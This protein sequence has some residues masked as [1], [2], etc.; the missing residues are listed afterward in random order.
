MTPKYDSVADPYIDPDTGVLRNLLGATTAEKLEQAEAALTANRTRMLRVEPLAGNFD[1]KH[2]Q[3]IHGY[4]FQDVYDWAG[5]LR[6]SDI[7]KNT[8]RFANW[9]SIESYM[10]G[11]SANIAD[12][13]HLLGLSPEQ[14]AEQAA[15]VM[16]EVNAVHPFREGNGRAQREFINH[17]A[18]N[19]GYLV[20]W[21]DAP[22]D[23]ILATTI[24]SF[25]GNEKPLANLIQS[26]LKPLT[27]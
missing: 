17:L 21:E 3:K 15:H 6:K 1:L 4:L 5:Q 20:A 8:S 12:K 18:V 16:A 22:V 2:L 26:H 27:R 25:H 14:F 24:R 13:D 19:A 23:A 11:V 7:T 9:L 10:A